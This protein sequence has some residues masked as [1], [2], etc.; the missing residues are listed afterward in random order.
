MIKKINTITPVELEEI[1]KIWLTANCEAH[2][3]ISESYWQENFAFVREQLPKADLYVYSE[4]NKIIAFLGL[5]EHYIA[6]IFV[7]N[8]Y[9]SKGIGQKLLN[10]VKRTH[11]TLSL[12]VYAK[13]QNAVKFYEKQGFK[14][15]NQQTDDTGELEYQL[16]WKK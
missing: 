15:L 13:N 6:G 8:D 4:N 5:N 7:R 12:S 16:V 2:P 14:Q 1:M 10:E 3:F 9:R 11:D